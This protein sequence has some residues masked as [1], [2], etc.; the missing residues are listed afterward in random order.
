M[1]TEGALLLLF[2]VVMVIGADNGSTGG[3]IKLSRI[4]VGWSAVVHALR[5]PSLPDR[6][7]VTLRFKGKPVEDGT[8]V[9]LLALAAIYALAMVLVW[10]HFL[11]HGYAA[12]PALFDTVS[13]LSTVG[14][15]TTI[16][17]DLPPDLKLSLTFAM[18]LGRLEF[19]AVIVL[20]IPKT[21]IKRR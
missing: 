19:I 17:A 4:S 14:L 10:G 8:L 11:L 9:S 16:G 20:L 3:G 2:V 7:V 1:P 18:W 15:S 13:T 6:A 21:W 12:G 5:T